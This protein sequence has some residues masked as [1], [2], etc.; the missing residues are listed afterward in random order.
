PPRNVARSFVLFR[1]SY[2]HGEGSLQQHS[3]APLVADV[4]YLPAAPMTRLIQLG[5]IHDQQILPRLLTPLQRLLPMG[6]LNLLRTKLDMIQEP[7][8]RFEF[9]PLR[10]SLWQR[11]AGPLR[12]TGS[13]F[14]QPL[15]AASV[16]QSG[17][18]KLRFCPLGRRPQGSSH[19]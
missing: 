16:P 6:L 13:H 3:T 10:K 4:S 1:A 17:R 8:S 12:Q 19:N 11:S 15:G 2:S 18:R 14:Y 7:V 5:G 9:I